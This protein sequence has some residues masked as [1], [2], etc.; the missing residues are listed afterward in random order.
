MG[1]SPEDVVRQWITSW[2]HMT[3]EVFAQPFSDDC[4][5]VDTPRFAVRGIDEVLAKAQ[6]YPDTRSEIKQLVANDGTVM[7]ERIDHFEFRGR[8]FA[9]PCVGVF[10]VDGDGRMTRFQDY[11]DMKDF[12]DQ[13]AAAGISTDGIE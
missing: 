9:L 13:V 7:V 8:A 12:I 11:Y 1:R 2:E 10:E 5:Y 3:P 4:F 6:S